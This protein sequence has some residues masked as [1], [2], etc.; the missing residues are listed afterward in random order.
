MVSRA[1]LVLARAR[2]RR[3]GTTGVVLAVVLSTS[4]LAQDQRKDSAPQQS[5]P[6]PSYAEK[7]GGLKKLIQDILK[8]AKAGNQQ[9]LDAYLNG[10]VIPDP[11]S[12]FKEVFGDAEGAAFAKTYAGRRGRL[13]S[14]LSEVFALAIQEKMTDIDVRQFDKACDSD[15]NEF[16][17]PLLAAREQ[18]QRLYEVRLFQGTYG[19]VLW[20]FAYIDGA[21]RY[22]GDLRLS[23][24]H[25]SKS[26]AGGSGRAP[27]RGTESEPTRIRVGGAVQQA[28]LIRQVPPVYPEEAKRIGLQGTVHLTAAIGTDGSVEDLKVIEGR[29]SLAQAA[30]S[31]V[32]KWRYTPTLVLGQPVRVV[33]TIDVNFALSQ[34]R[35]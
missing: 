5:P 29:C 6:L 34:R 33:T 30:A 28:R 9:M 22:L 31:A 14:E 11:A 24:V 23:G 27:S 8:T 20:P 4:A 10:L 7:P 3:L 19:K 13:P 16:Q 21:F 17:Y 2:L 26:S 15:A 18:L 1:L 25:F 35:F 32:R 12:W